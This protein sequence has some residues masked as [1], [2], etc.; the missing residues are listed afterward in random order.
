M[1]RIL[2]PS[3]LIVTILTGG[4]LAYSIWKASPVTSQ[5]YFESGK[6]FYEQKKYSEATVQFLNAVQKDPKNRDARY[7]L[8]LT[9]ANQKNLNAAARQLIALLEYLPDDMEASLELGNIYLTGGRTDSE[10]F[11]KAAEMAQ[12]VLSKEP[13]NVAA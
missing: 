13:E 8:A 12:K 3:I 6:K 10:F 4:V 9:Y 7:L 2:Y 11:R 1:K 5:Q